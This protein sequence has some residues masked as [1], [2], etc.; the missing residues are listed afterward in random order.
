VGTA[1]FPAIGLTLHPS[2]GIGAVASNQI[3][4]RGLS[5]GPV[6]GNQTQLVLVRLRP[7]VPLAAG[8]VVG[9]R[10]T[11]A[12]NAVFAHVPTSATCSNDSMDLLTVQR[13]AEIVNYRTMGSTASELGGVLALAALAAL[14]ATLVASVQ[15]RRRDLAILKS[16]GLSRRQ[17]AATVAWQASVTMGVGVVVGVPL[18]VL[19][20]RWLWTLF[21]RAIY[22]VPEP[23]VPWTSIVIIA[24]AG[25]L[26]A[27]V[28]AMIPGR[29]AA[30]TPTAIVLRSE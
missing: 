14:A 25:M 6:C 23:T 30:R 13:P 15:R 1:T 11:A 2:L 10:I 19:L 4:G 24:V 20:G 28:A 22:V 12:T 18:G 16:L 9:R 8:L 27:N 26:F 29:I 21:A 5:E 3:L 17:L 7:G